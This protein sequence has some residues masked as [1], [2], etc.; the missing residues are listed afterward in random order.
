MWHPQQCDSGGLC[1]LCQYDV[2][3]LLASISWPQE[4]LGSVEEAG[5]R[6]EEQPQHRPSPWRVLYNLIMGLLPFPRGHRAPE[7]EPN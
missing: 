2:Y 6:Q 3:P 7:M 5:L 1:N 4:L